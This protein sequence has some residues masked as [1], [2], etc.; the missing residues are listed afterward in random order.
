[1]DKR[2]V[3]IIEK[4]DFDNSGKLDPEEIAVMK[5]EFKSTG[6]LQRVAGYSAVMARAFRYLAFTSDFGEALRPVASARLVNAS[7][8]V[9]GTVLFRQMYREVY[10]VL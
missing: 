4:Y 6:T 5:H 9:A 10:C 1:M 8:A 2:I 3:T 7:Y